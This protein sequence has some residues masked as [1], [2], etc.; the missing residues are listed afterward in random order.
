MMLEARVSDDSIAY[1]V[2]GLH[3]T[4]WRTIQ[5]RIQAGNEY[6]IVHDAKETRWE[7]WT[8]GECFMATCETR[9]EAEATLRARLPETRATVGQLV[10]DHDAGQRSPRPTRTD[11]KQRGQAWLLRNWI[12][13][14]GAGAILTGLV[15]LGVAVWLGLV[16]IA[17][18]VITLIVSTSNGNE[19][20][21]L[22]VGGKAAALP[23]VVLGAGGT[24]VALIALAAFLVAGYLFIKAFFVALRMFFEEEMRQ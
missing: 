21:R 6:A 5:A 8:D 16:V 19:W 20:D 24:V 14:A 18:G 1:Y 12:W 23:G 22:P 2:Q 3:P 10:R 4:D 13:L 15:L 9:A 11:A 7:V 17:C